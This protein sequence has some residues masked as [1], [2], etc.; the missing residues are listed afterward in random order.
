MDKVK[1]YYFDNIK[2]IYPLHLILLIFTPII[3]GFFIDFD[4]SNERD[5]IINLIWI[6]LFTIPYLLY[7]KKIIYYFITILFFV[8]GFINLTHWL[9][10]DG[11]ITI[12]S[13]LVISNTNLNESI[14]Y[15]S[16]K[17]TFKLLILF[18]YT[19]F[20]IRSLKIKKQDYNKPNYYIYVIIALISIIFISENVIRHRLIR[21]GSPLL[22][23]VGASFINEMKMFNEFSKKTLPRKIQASSSTTDNQTFVLILGESANKK[24]M[25]IYDYKRK[26]SPLLG[27]RKD[28][29][30]F[31]NTVSPYSNTIN[32]VLTILSESNL[33]N[34]ISF[35]NSIDIIDVFHAAGF[36]TYWISNQSPI[37]VWDNVVTSFAKK[38]D[39]VKFVNISSN[40][41]FEATLNVSYDSKLFTPFISALKES[42]PKKFIVLHL[43]GSHSSYKKRYPSDYRVF[44]NETSG[45]EKTI[46]QYDNS[47][48]YNDFIVDS[49]LNSLKSH[50]TG[51][52]SAVYI[53]DHGENVYDEKNNVGHNYTGKL[54]NANV[55]IPFIVWLSPQFKNTYTSQTNTILNNV[56]TPFVSDD[57]FHSIIN[58]NNIETPTLDTTR[59]I[60]SK[61]F[62]SFRKRILE[63]GKEYHQN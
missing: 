13:L 7:P 15:L 2:N 30:R 42:V 17:S 37:G 25:S 50:G 14:E 41:S 29:I 8:S 36:K 35:N 3:I 27:K 60:F 11:P 49:L 58:L 21:K 43:M 45:Q 23:K 52:S 63:D 47:I 6:P 40:S 1:S 20:F 16:L 32:S 46:A 59:S 34:K 57:L 18:P 4:L 9:L 48:L 54:P 62:N 61:G 22:V 5:I 51:L 53:S 55:E 28:I 33:E 24:H 10:L 38:S 26:T 31:N 56:N 19:Y 12:T 39:V 44:E